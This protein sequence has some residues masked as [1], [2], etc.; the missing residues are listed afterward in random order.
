MNTYENNFNEN[1]NAPFDKNGNASFGLPSNYFDSFESKLR[2]KL[3]LEIELQDYAVLSSIQK[4]NTFTLP[5]E[6]FSSLEA[7]LDFQTELVEFPN[8]Q[9]IKPNLSFPFDSEYHESF[10]NK[11]I[12]KI[13]SAEELTAFKILNSLNK[14][15]FYVCPNDYFENLAS[16]IKEKIHQPKISI[17]GNIFHFIFNKK[18]ALSFSVIIIA[19]LS[20]LLYPKNITESI[21]EGNCKTLACLE[22]QEILNNAKAI[23]SLD[24]DQLIELVNIKKLDNQLNS[25]KKSESKNAEADSFIN[26]SNLDEIID[27]L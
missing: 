21:N 24:E 14:Q 2:Q 13:E 22:K 15:N 17:F 9:S 4:T 10:R 23:S 19:F 6:Y 1:Q 3:E 25:T 20:W 27:E 18:M 26:D 5:K 7:K 11:L 12:T 8:L 16:D